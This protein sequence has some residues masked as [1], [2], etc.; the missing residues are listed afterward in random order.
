MLDDFTIQLSKCEHSLW[1]LK[2]LWV[3]VMFQ[4][5]QPSTVRAQLSKCQFKFQP[6]CG[7]ETKCIFLYCNNTCINQFVLTILTFYQ[8][9]NYNQAKCYTLD[10]Q[11]C[12]YCLLL[13]CRDSDWLAHTGF[14]YLF[15]PSA[16]NAILAHE[17]LWLQLEL[18]LQVKHYCASLLA[19]EL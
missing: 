4:Q 19:L 15:N 14:S 17:C 18:A 7:Q 12:V 2:W 9:K 1:W 16:W 5:Y 11:P 3:S 8:D 6:F 13:K 10:L